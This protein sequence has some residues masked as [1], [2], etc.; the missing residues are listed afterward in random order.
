VITNTAD[1]TSA[2]FPTPIKSN[3]AVLVI[4]NWPKLAIQKYQTSNSI[5]DA[6]GLVEPGNTINYTLLV[7]NTGLINANNV[8]VTD[9][10][11]VSTTYTPGTATCNKLT[12]AGGCSAGV[13]LGTVT[14]TI[15]V[16][17][18]N[19]VAQLKFSVKVDSPNIDGRIIPNFGTLGADLIPP[20]DSNIVSYQVIARPNLQI[21]KRVSPASGSVVHP[22]DTLTYTIVVTNTGTTSTD[23]ALIK[24]TLPSSV[25][26]VAGS[27][28]MSGVPVL[29]PPGG[30]APVVNGTGACSPG[31]C[32]PGG[33]GGVL[34]VYDPAT[35]QVEIATLVFQVK[36]KNPIDN[37]VIIP[38]FACVATP[39]T[40]E[41]C[42]NTVTNK[43]FSTPILVGKKINSPTGAVVPG[44]LINYSL[45]FTNTGTMTATNVV[46]TDTVPLG[47]TYVAASCTPACT[48][49][50]GLLTWS[51]QT[52]N[53]GQAK[54]YAFSVTVN[55]PPPVFQNINNQG[56][57]KY[58]RYTDQVNPDTDPGTPTVAPTNIVT[59]PLA[60]L[61]PGLQ[62]QK[63][64]KT[65][66]GGVAL[67]GGTVVFDIVVKNTG[68]SRITNWSISDN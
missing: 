54:N 23:S 1:I 68:L 52:F 30:I 6:Q 24:D 63:T 39:D 20:V 9:V 4:N 45:T 42:S 51:G 11:P 57:A 3:A 16:L 26:Y 5:Y 37:G 33:D 10:V 53:P 64:L 22:G 12:P 28:T 49:G 19:Q 25:T 50:A 44:D 65:P 32:N 56:F 67:I 15:G 29:D 40:T 21:S 8:I 61:P 47:S 14:F 35:P 18:P 55:S 27:T 36:V 2:E 7:T 17:A 31:Y 48:F 41:I 60:F 43:V 58:T 34:L 38:D 59:N 46:I 66:A 62:I 13:A